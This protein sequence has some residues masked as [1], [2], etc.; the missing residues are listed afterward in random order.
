MEKPMVT[1]L[2][3]VLINVATLAESS[4]Q[5]QKVFTKLACAKQK[6]VTQGL[7]L[8]IQYFMLNDS[9]YISEHSNVRDTLAVMDAALSKSRLM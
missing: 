4:D 1:F 9:T 3:K 8:F 2:R 7:Q 5:L 6:P